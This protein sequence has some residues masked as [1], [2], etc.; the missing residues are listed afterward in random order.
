MKILYCSYSQIPSEF[1][2]S[3][4]V[5]KQCSALNKVVRLRA[6]LVRGKFG[7]RKDPFS[8]Y[9]VAPFPLVL[10]PKVALR[11]REFG[12]K[13]FVLFYSIIFRPDVVYSRDLILN[14]W[15]CRFHINN[16]YEIHQI[17]QQDSRFDCYYKKQL[18]RTMLRKELQAVVCI[19]AGL[20]DECIA[21]GIPKEKLTVLHSSKDVHEIENAPQV[22]LPSFPAARPLAVYV[23][24][25]QNGK[26]IEQIEAMARMSGNYNFLIVGGK[27]GD[28]PEQ[29]NLRHIPHM[30]HTQALS[31]MKKADFLLLPMTEQNYKFHSPLKLFEY[32]ST[33]KP[34]I[35]SD[36]S[37]VREILK[38]RQNG[39]LAQP[40]NPKDFLDKMDD[41]R[42]HPELQKHLLIMSQ[43]SSAAYT[44][45]SRAKKIV[46][47]I[48][49]LQHE[50]CN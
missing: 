17:T 18:F 7:E 29:S 26:G 27:K 13:V 31:Y 8:I 23:G 22:Q 6:V 34:I 48:R 36:N 20:A 38:H 39:M 19:S 33:G 47:L 37:D 28:I 12:L 24:S 3:I 41:V 14:A 15:L 50:K 4:A 43:Q 35:A 32:L 25:L 2:N 1:A 42:K 46:Y 44:W 16:I 5:M 45:D 21:F 9:G 49:G 30:S 40:G 10:I 11:M